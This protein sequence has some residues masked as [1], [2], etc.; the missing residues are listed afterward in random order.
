LQPHGF[1]SWV[2]LELNMSIRIC[3][4]ALAA[5]GLASGLGACATAPTE[6]AEVMS[7]RGQLTVAG[8]APSEALG[9]IDPQ[10]IVEHPTVENG[11]GATNSEPATPAASP[12]VSIEGVDPAAALAAVDTTKLVDKKQ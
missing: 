3:A 12:G 1:V 2:E 10:K 6:Q 8:I 7:N 9:A 5:A 11:A 4:F